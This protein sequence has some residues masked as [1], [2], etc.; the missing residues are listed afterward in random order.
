MNSLPEMLQIKAIEKNRQ[1]RV[2][3]FACS[4]IEIDLLP[5]VFEALIEIGYSKRLDLVLY[6]RGGVVNAARRLMH[7]LHEFTDH[8]S[9]LV[10]HHCESSGTIMTLGAHEVIAGPLAL[11]SPIDPLLNSAH[12]QDDGTPGAISAQD[13]R[14]FGEMARNW[15]RLDERDA[16]VQSLSMLSGSIFPTTL[17]SFYRS[18]LELQEISEQL[19]ALQMPEESIENRSKIIDQLLFGYHSHSYYLTRDELKEIGLKVR[20]DPEI[21]TLIWDL[22]RWISS[23]IGSGL[24]KSPEDSWHDTLIATADVT[25]IRQ[26]QPGTI[27]TDWIVSSA[28]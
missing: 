11:F 16:C 15:F 28:P 3:V 5:S 4:N 20:C 1:S 9:V 2:L 27:S 7:L 12:A 17:T 14:L 23:V 22:A 10:P 26:R 18:T 6:C 21:E 13:I 24:R 25:H 19:L 8:L